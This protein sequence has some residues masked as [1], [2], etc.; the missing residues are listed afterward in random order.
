[1]E[2]ASLLQP[3][4]TVRQTDNVGNAVE[5]T[6]ENLNS[7]I[8]SDKEKPFE[9]GSYMGYLTQ[10]RS[11]PVI[12]TEIESTKTHAVAFVAPSNY[13]GWWSGLGKAVLY[14]ARGAYKGAAWAGAGA[15]TAYAI[16][17]VGWIAGTAATAAGAVY[18]TWSEGSFEAIWDGF[19]GD[20][21]KDTINHILIADNTKVSEMCYD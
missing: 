1:M 4:K 13:K 14:N 15:T 17:Y 20:V 16:P 21:K 7:S 18:G 6:V 2:I 19:T 3:L 12:E 5:A 8:Q 10:G 11:F 9:S